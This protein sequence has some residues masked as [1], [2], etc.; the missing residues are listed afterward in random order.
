MLHPDFVPLWKVN[1]PHLGICY[2][3]KWSL[4]ELLFRLDLYIWNPVGRLWLWKE[5]YPPPPNAFGA[6]TCASPPG[7]HNATSHA[8]LAPL[9]IALKNPCQNIDRVNN[10]PHLGVKMP[11]RCWM[12]MHR[13]QK[14]A[15]GSEI[16][17]GAR[18]PERSRATGSGAS[19]YIRGWWKR[20]MRS[21][22]RGVPQD[23]VST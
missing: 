19:F 3:Y 7:W 22:M 11:R 2:Y 10:T 23:R 8:T 4:Q 15:K 20:P 13:T 21:R 5:V 17:P 9:I 12:A 16:Q 6:L 18:I 14:Q 1:V